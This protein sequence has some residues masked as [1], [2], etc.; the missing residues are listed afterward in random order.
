MQSHIV[1]TNNIE[2]YIE[3]FAIGKRHKIYID[4][5]F[6][7]ETSREVIAEAY[8]SSEVEKFL[9]LGASKFNIPAQNALLKV[10]EEPPK[11][12]TFLIVTNSKASL[13][14]TI[15]SRLPI[16]DEKNRVFLADISFDYTRYDLKNMYEIIHLYKKS[17]KQEAKEFVEALFLHISTTIKLNE[18]EL[19]IF[20]NSIRLLELNSKPINVIINILLMLLEKKFKK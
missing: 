13:L 7:V 5:E 3:N 2:K 11:N 8:I 18:Y 15:K 16:N 1:I 9:I 14:P 19:E 20:S 10:L 6:K 17:T 4:D 12:I